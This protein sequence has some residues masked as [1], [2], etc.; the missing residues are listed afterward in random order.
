M[1]LPKKNTHPDK[2]IISTS[3]FIL[4]ILREKG[5]IKYSDLESC[6]KKRRA[7]IAP[8]LM[9]SLCFLFLFGRIN[10]YP[11]SDTLEYI[12]QTSNR[13]DENETI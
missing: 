6:I 3:C 2:T 5:I 9:P 11:K 4:P 10:Y 7:D 1:L 8:L 12:K 13:V